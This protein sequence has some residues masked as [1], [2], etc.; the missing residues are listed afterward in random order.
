MVS[1]MNNLATLQRFARFLESELN[2]AANEVISDEAV[3]AL[4]EAIV[5]AANLS[6]LISQANGWDIVGRRKVRET[7]E[8]K[9]V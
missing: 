6:V 5:M 1:R 2:T 7:R 8:K 4:D 3:K 9:S